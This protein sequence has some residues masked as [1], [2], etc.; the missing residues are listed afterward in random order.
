MAVLFAGGFITMMAIFGSA[1]AV[2]W[3]L[4]FV[5]SRFAIS[6]RAAA[7]KSQPLGYWCS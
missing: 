1:Y 7:T 4:F 2:A 6:D 3:F 5:V